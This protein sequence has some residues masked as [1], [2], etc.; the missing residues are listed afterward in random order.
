NVTLIMDDKKKIID[1]LEKETGEKISILDALQRQKQEKG[2]E[3]KLITQK[4]TKEI[5][6]TYKPQ[7]TEKHTAEYIKQSKTSSKYLIPEFSNY[8]IQQR[9]REAINDNLI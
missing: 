2:Q 3:N 6:K 5:K 9:F 4:Q 8:E 7:K 1:R